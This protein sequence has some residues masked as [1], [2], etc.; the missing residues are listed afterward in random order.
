MVEKSCN[1]YHVTKKSSYKD[2]VNEG[3]KPICDKSNKVIPWCENALY[4]GT[5]LD[6]VIEIGFEN[7]QENEEDH[8]VVLEVPILKV[9][10]NCS[11][12]REEDS[13]IIAYSGD[14]KYYHNR[15]C[16][17]KNTDMKVVFDSREW[18]N[19]LLGKPVNTKQ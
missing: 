1:L 14:D 15:K 19:S 16:I 18:E 13:N 17:I 6:K 7:I 8:F 5:D 2:I 11:H 3:L 4:F 10:K 9:F 12:L